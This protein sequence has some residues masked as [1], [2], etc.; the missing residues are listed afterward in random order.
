MFTCDTTCSTPDAIGAKSLIQ[1]MEMEFISTYLLIASRKQETRKLMLLLLLLVF[2]VKLITIQCQGF[3]SFF[4]LFGLERNV[5][6]AVALI[7]PLSIQC[8]IASRGL[9]L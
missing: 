2:P 8:I 3:V 1:Y 6:N 4:S 5:F 9:L 7:F